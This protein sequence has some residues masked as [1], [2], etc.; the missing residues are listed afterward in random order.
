MNRFTTAV[1]AIA[2]ISWLLM[3]HKTDSAPLV[4]LY[5]L[6]ACMHGYVAL[7]YR[8]KEAR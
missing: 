2:S 5:M 8:D 3:A 4:V 1:W 7:I 6:L